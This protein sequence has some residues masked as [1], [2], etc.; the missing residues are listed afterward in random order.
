MLGVEVEGSFAWQE[1]TDPKVGR[2]DLCK[3]LARA[4]GQ[5]SEMVSLQ[6]FLIE[7]GTQAPQDI[8]VQIPMVR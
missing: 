3:A 2:Q 4:K 8:V 6:K 5:L 1:A 7:L